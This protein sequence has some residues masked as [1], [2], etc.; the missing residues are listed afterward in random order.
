MAWNISGW[1][2]SQPFYIVFL[3]LVLVIVSPFSLE[4]EHEHD[5]EEATFEHDKGGRGLIFRRGPIQPH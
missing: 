5:Y 2:R 3:V 4:H 1:P